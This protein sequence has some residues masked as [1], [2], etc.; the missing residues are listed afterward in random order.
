MDALCSASGELVFGGSGISAAELSRVEEL[1]R[2]CGA[3]MSCGQ[4]DFLERGTHLFVR[5]DGP[6]CEKR[7]VKVLAV[8]ASGRALRSVAW[9]AK[10]DDLFRA[11]RLPLDPDAVAQLRSLAI[12]DL[13]LHRIG[14]AVDRALR[15]CAT[16]KKLF[17]GVFVHLAAA[18]A[19]GRGP[20]RRQCE[21][22]LRAGGATLV[23]KKELLRRAKEDAEGA[24]HYVRVV[25]SGDARPA[26]GEPNVKY[27]TPNWIVEAIASFHLFWT[28]EDL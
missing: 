20:D 16:G 11:G 10:L 27:V 22:L 9:L 5:A 2:R 25:R 14:G 17:H 24:A 23:A 8:L 13:R 1:A 18:F 6:L 15:S 7:T 3:R 26:A 28:E 19:G 12:T 4:D 21:A